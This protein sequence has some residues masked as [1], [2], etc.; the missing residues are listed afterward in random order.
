[1]AAKQSFADLL[2]L[3]SSNAQALQ[4]LG[5]AA[6][7][8]MYVGQYDKAS[9]VFEALSILAPNDPVG[10]LGCAEIMLN[11]G[12]FKESEKAAQQASQA[13]NIAR[14]PLAFAHVLRGQA[15]MGQSKAKDAEK[16]WQKACEIDPD[17]ATAATA[18]ARIEIARLCGKLPAAAAAAK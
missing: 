3:K 10:Y 1:M 6:Y 4:F 8:W 2:G 12:K 16:A 11:Q 18:K 9:K 13:A 17:G 5:E 7:L 15:L 14:G